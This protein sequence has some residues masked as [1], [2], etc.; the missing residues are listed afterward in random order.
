[1][2]GKGYFMEEI[3]EKI[4]SEIDSIKEEENKVE[5]V[6]QKSA[7]LRQEEKQLKEELDTIP[8]T[9]SGFYQDLKA[10][11]DDKHQEFIT[12]DSERRNQEKELNDLIQKKKEEIR[13]E[14]ADKKHYIDENRNVNLEN[15]DII[16]LKEEKA[17]L[18]KEI[19]LNG[20]TK[21][22][23]DT[24]TDSEK[25]EIRKAK[26]NYLNNKKRLDEIN[27]MIQLSDTLDGRMPIEMFKD[28]D[29]LD[30]KIEKN[31]NKKGLDTIM[32]EIDRRNKEREQDDIQKLLDDMVAGREKREEERYY[33]DI[34]SAIEETEMRKQEEKEQEQR[35]EEAEQ[36]DLLK[37]MIEGRE[38]REE[39]RYRE[40]I[41]N[42]LAETRKRQI[43]EKMKEGMTEKKKGE[44]TIPRKEAE[45]IFV[46][47]GRGAT[48][49]YHGEEY[50][51]ATRDI[52][53]GLGLNSLEDKELKDY[54][55]N[56]I[57]IKEKNLDF[58][59]DLV[60]EGVVD[61][62]IIHAIYSTDMSRNKKS[63]ALNDYIAKVQYAKANVKDETKF[64]VI[65]D[66]QDLSK[67]GFFGRLFKQ[68]V[69][70]DEKLEIYNNAIKSEKHGLGRIRGE[71][72]PSRLE[73]FFNKIT[74]KDETVKFPIYK[75]EDVYEVASMYNEMGY[76]KDGNKL[77]AKDVKKSFKKRLRA[78]R[79]LEEDDKN[80]MSYE[81]KMELKDLVKAHKSP[82]QQEETKQ[83]EQEERE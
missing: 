43:E 17:K 19:E 12:A 38:K 53:Y 61:M 42:G 29:E 8:D 40:D 47:I 62:T 52:K 23:F 26:E 4:R 79:K 39:E 82:I 20:I 60:R 73:R 49:S 72:K 81:Q 77:E 57:R 59:K 35:R 66:M 14:L 50:E 76:D 15:V 74:G 30:R 28:I 67:A 46:T 65:Y 54:L 58:M 64:H 24:K 18:D 75:A 71:Y 22:E 83:E 33:E 44:K 32:N 3:L 56:E 63:V 37:D 27:P 21:E 34:Q 48:V 1:M 78:D 51:V 6:A 10:K 70:T 41:K 45:P 80:K 25:R 55:K 36:E 68:E 31:F 69:N 13:K 11:L 16:K 5:E 9:N 2:Y 7:E